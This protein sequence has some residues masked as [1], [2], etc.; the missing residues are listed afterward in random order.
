MGRGEYIATPFLR[1][2]EPWKT[3]CEKADNGSIKSCEITLRSDSDDA[4][5]IIL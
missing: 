4:S 1:I 5:K 3:A 2:K